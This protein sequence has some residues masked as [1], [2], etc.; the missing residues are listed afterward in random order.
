MDK[1]GEGETLLGTS[2]MRAADL[3]DAFVA[4]DAA[5]A[6]SD[7]GASPKWT[8][9]SFG[10]GGD[11][12]DD[13]EDDRLGPA[14][15]DRCSPADGHSFT[16]AR[17]AELESDGDDASEAGS[18]HSE[19]SM[20]PLVEVAGQNDSITPHDSALPATS[21]QSTP[22]P[23]AQAPRGGAADF[24]F[25]LVTGVGVGA[26]SV[27]PVWG[28]LLS[29]G[30]SVIPATLATAAAAC[31]DA[32]AGGESLSRREQLVARMAALPSP[33]EPAHVRQLRT[34]ADA[35]GGKEAFAAHVG[36]AQI[37]LAKKV[38]WLVIVSSLPFP[39][40]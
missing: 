15:A 21:R 2:E 29:S 20:L 35:L 25:S 13:A 8:I 31:G 24:T 22:E 10:A 6:N 1:I 34:A 28:P 16:A 32:H 23:S 14:S 37:L 40:L 3:L 5:A 33:P 12:E 4:A 11:A 27:S 26:S 17:L 19:L 36:M 38:P 39:M 7:A 30:R 9:A 18:G